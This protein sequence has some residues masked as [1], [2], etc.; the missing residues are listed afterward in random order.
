MVYKNNSHKG[1][2][3]MANFVSNDNATSLM[4]AIN[5]KKDTKPVEITYAEW[6]VLTDEERAGTHYLITD[7][8]E[9][10]S[11][12]HVIQNASGTDMAQQPN[13]QFTDAA[14]S[15]DGTNSRTKVSV[16]QDP[17]TKSAFEQASDLP[18]GLYPLE[19][20]EEAVMSADMISYGEGTVK[21]ALDN[22]MRK[23]PR[24]K[25]LGTFTTTAQLET[26]LSNM[27]V[28]T[29]TFDGDIQIGD[30]VTIAGYTCYVAGFDT[31]YNKGDS[32]LTMH[33]I[34]FIANVGNSK[35]NETSTTAGGYEGASTMK[36]FLSSKETELNAICG[37]HLLSR[38]CLTTNVVTN[39][40]S[41]GWGWNTH[42]LTLMSETQIYG[43]IQWGNV[44]DTGEGYERLPI[45]NYLTPLQ[46]LGR[47]SV[48]LRG[49][50]NATD[51]CYSDRSG[52][53][54]Y[55]YASNSRA[56]GALFC[57]G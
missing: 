15:N 13:M 39:G 16:M 24:M 44:R 2:F 7:V 46:V 6:I 57:I 30:Y 38:R 33:H 20:P 52:E 56:M 14:V 41:S 47:L 10:S 42:K 43:G 35:M 8:P 1:G 26:F 29:G 45:F 3:K 19:T 49:V 5:S 25:N 53:P 32:E 23:F 31:E 40:K 37:D 54:N 22:A 17:M 34:T 28:S 18:D 50:A 9:Q 48:W 55:D 36:S 11:S 21:K 4:N 12:G 27:G 51:F